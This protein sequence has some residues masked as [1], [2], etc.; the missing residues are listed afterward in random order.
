MHFIHSFIH[1][2]FMEHMLHMGQEWGAQK[3]MGLILSP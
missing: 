3:S 2:T 1:S